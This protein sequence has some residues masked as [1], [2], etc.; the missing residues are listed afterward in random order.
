MP[1][2]LGV[3]VLALILGPSAWVRWQIRR[4][5]ADRPD[6]PGTGG[7][8]ARHLLDRAGLTTVGV[9]PTERGDHY[10]PRARVVRLS[11]PHFDGRSISAVAVAA[12][13]VGHALQH[14]DRY[15]PL[16]ARERLV[17]STAWVRGFAA[18]MIPAAPVLAAATHAPPVALAALGAGVLSMGVLVLVHLVT[19]PVE[20]DASFAR[21]L[22]ILEGGYLD[23]ADLSDARGVLRAAALTYVASA[24][25]AMLNVVRWLRGLR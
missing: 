7:E 24:A 8:L 16:M 13:E 20:W 21:A 10:D 5:Q 19:L 3:L 2:L 11:P 1:V 12:H 14:R 25:M 4:H 15:A 6:L 23:R 9:E 17:R 22:P 18:L